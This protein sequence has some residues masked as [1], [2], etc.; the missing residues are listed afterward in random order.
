MMK[1]ACMSLHSHC[2]FSQIIEFSMSCNSFLVSLRNTLFN[3]W[4]RRL[5]DLSVTT[6]M[7]INSHGPCHMV[8]SIT[9]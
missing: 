5:N 7:I 6:S 4:E 9:K 3:I 2:L 1:V 8:V